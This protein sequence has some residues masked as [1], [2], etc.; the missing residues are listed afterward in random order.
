MSAKTVMTR[1]FSRKSPTPASAA[2]PV[3]I[4]P[5]E[6]PSSLNASDSPIA[7]RLRKAG[8]PQGVIDE[9][10]REWAPIMAKLADLPLDDQ[11]YWKQVEAAAQ[12]L[13]V[14]IHSNPR[15][16]K[17]MLFAVDWS[18]SRALR[19]VLHGLGVADAP[20][21][22]PGDQRQ[23]IE[24]PSYLKGAPKRNPIVDRIRSGR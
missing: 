6:A 21:V 11:E 1:L 18:I 8:V 12:K 2:P 24:L 4:E 19:A 16:Q 7:A 22:S 23:L 17:Q 14:T 9:V 10:N 3:A 15:I 20:Q 5:S 13:E